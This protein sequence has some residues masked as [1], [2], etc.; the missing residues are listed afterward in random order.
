MTAELALNVGVR[1]PVRLL[2]MTGRRSEVGVELEWEVV[3]DEGPSRFRVL[4]EAA[5]G[6]RVLTPEPL[7]GEDRFRF[8]DRDAPRTTLTYWLEGSDRT[9]ESTRFGPIEV[10][11]G[12]S[13]T[14][15]RAAP[16]PFSGRL[17]LGYTLAA[18]G[19]A[20]IV[21]LDIQG[22]RRAVLLDRYQP[23]GDHVLFWDGQIDG[24]RAPAGLYWVRFEGSGATVTTKV[25]SLGR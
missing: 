9:G 19:P 15:L 7:W 1:T 22:R 14:A 13:V 2:S 5:E 20:R 25:L 4:R 17:R 24:Q 10:A 6:P 16:N 21:V 11:A 18:A 23:A 3:S 12:L 8:V